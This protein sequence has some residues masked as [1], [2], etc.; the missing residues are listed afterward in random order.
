VLGWLQSACSICESSIPLSRAVLICIST[1]GAS[2]SDWAFGSWRVG[3]VTY[4]LGPVSDALSKDNLQLTKVTSTTC[5]FL[6]SHYSLDDEVPIPKQVGARLSRRDSFTTDLDLLRLFCRLL[7]Q[8]P[9]PARVPTGGVYP[10]R[11]RSIGKTTLRTRYARNQ[12]VDRL[13]L[14]LRLRKYFSN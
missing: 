6:H 7:L 2:S 14:T 4:T 5:R 11:P 8:L 9:R 10:T 3:V 1:H 12:H 13:L